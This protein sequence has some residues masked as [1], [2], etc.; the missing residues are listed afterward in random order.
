[1]V[2]AQIEQLINESLVEEAGMFSAMGAATSNFFNG[3][4]DDIV[5]GINATTSSVAGATNAVVSG[6]K[7]DVTAG[8]NAVS[9]TVVGAGKS[10]AK[11]VTDLNT[12]AHNATM[13]GINKGV[14]AVNKLV[15][16]SMATINKAYADTLTAVDSYIKVN[17]P[18]AVVSINKSYNDTSEWIKNTYNQADAGVNKILVK[19]EFDKIES[20]GDIK[21]VLGFTLNY[22][23]W[24]NFKKA[25]V[26]PSDIADRIANTTA[27]GL[28][29]DKSELMQYGLWGGIGLG[30]VA[31]SLAA[32]GIFKSATQ[33]KSIIPFE[34]ELKKLA[35]SESKT[36]KKLYADSIKARDNAVRQNINDPQKVTSI[37]FNTLNAILIAIMASRAAKT[38][39]RYKS[40]GEFLAVN[41]DIHSV[42]NKYSEFYGDA[43]S[44]KPILIAFDKAVVASN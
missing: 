6:V 34:R 11:A 14:G 22:K 33:V 43:S 1:M 35:N 28:G 38:S 27:N 20:S 40:A 24:D 9:D 32:Y 36:V 5:T 26:S 12:S 23:N 31:G 2:I 30:V 16:S 25:G 15:D 10:A 17:T 37:Y 4:K 42:V 41:K 29:V 8:F 44:F 19:D 21:S 39:N 18:K 13:S 3:L 7:S